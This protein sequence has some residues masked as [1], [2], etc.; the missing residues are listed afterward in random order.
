MYGT[1]RAV[2]TVEA[3]TLHALTVR[4]EQVTMMLEELGKL[5]SY[6]LST[7]TD[8]FLQSFATFAPSPFQ[9]F[10]GCKFCQVGSALDFFV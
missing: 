2:L 5:R 9:H 6:L 7:G 10:T 4:G 3:L 8:V 1:G